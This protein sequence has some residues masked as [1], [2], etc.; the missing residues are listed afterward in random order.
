MFTIS[1]LM[2]LWL[3]GF[4]ATFTALASEWNGIMPLHSTRADVVR[5]LGPS[6][7][8]NNEWSSHHRTTNEV[9]FVMYATGPPCGSNGVNSWKVPKGTV[10]SV[11]VRSKNKLLLTALTLDLSK[12][13]K[14]GG[15][16]VPGYSYYSNQR[17]G[18]SIEVYGDDVTGITYFA[19]DADIG[20]RCCPPG[21]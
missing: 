2:C 6:A 12:F 20:L 16:H 18:M 5:I 11:T 21:T 14:S 10:V 4:G 15:G 3:I 9:V 7:E 13:E 19:G 1:R 17:E 8:P